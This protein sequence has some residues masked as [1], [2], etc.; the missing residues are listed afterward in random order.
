VFTKQ[1]I[2]LIEMEPVAARPI[3]AL[4]SVLPQRA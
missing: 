4:G 1:I 2:E 3:F